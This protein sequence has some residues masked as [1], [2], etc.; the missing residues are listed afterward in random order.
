[1]N[2][3][4]KYKCCAAEK[5][6]EGSAARSSGKGSTSFSEGKDNDSGADAI[7]ANIFHG[8][9]FTEQ[10]STFQ[11]CFCLCRCCIHISQRKLITVY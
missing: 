5:E 10:K 7:Q 6:A 1:M 3:R 8:E 11:V 2:Y 4:Y 9:P